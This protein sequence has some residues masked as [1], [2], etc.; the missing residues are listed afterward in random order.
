MVISLSTAFNM[1]ELSEVLNFNKDYKTLEIK[2]VSDLLDPNPY[3][4][5]SNGSRL[6]CLRWGKT[7]WWDYQHIKGYKSNKREE[8]QVKNCV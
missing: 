1:N 8:D 4:P 5:L 2:T 7:D 3:G 6:R